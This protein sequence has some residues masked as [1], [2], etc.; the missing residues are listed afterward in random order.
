[1]PGLDA[2]YQ[3]DDYVTPLKDP[4]SQSLSS[5]ATALPNTLRPLTKLTYA[6][7]SSAGLTQASERRYVQSGLFLAATALLAALLL[8]AGLSP[9][10]SAAVATLWALHPVHAETLLALAGRSVL[11]SLVLILFSA[12]CLLRERFRL[13]LASAVLAV[14]A[15]ETAV[16]WLAACGGYVAL[17][18][19]LPRA[20]TFAATAAACALGLTLSLLSPRL[21]ALLTFSWDDPAALNR[22]GLQWAALPY[23]TFLWFASPMRFSVDIDFAPEGVVRLLY[24]VSA[25]VLYA[26]ALWLALRRQTP[27]HPRLA[28]VLWLSLV[29]P[30]HSV[31]PKLDPLTART[32][33]A[34]SAALC[35]LLAALLIGAL[36]AA[37]AARA[38]IFAWASALALLLW[39][40]PQTRERA[41][42]YLD[43]VALWRDAVE[44]GQGNARPLLNLGTLLAHQGRLEEAAAV[45]EAAVEKS[46]SSS[47][48]RHRLAAVRTLI[49]TQA[50]LT[51]PKRNESARIP[52]AT[53]SP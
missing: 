46:P 20:G 19:N 22:L 30:V 24:I 29:L 2:P 40:M 10:A 36:G 13:A 25:A 34:S 33:S 6:V 35:L 41:A 31:I 18:K 42:L 27:P 53:L 52:Q 44:Q 50:L 48:A 16:L 17:R 32:T 39:L 8:H 26:G 12:N 5:F 38:R 28:A 49:E 7:E 15:R 51:E 47:E 21:R 11:L 37:R 45:M 43:P 3:Y 14:L 4:A 23:E 9:T 1:M